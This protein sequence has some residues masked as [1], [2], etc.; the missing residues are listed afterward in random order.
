[1][2]VRVPEQMRDALVREIKRSRL[3]SYLLWFPL[4]LLI[5]V[6]VAAGFVFVRGHLETRV[7]Q[8]ILDGLL[9]EHIL[10]RLLWGTVLVGAS[11][12]LFLLLWQMYREC[13]IEEYL[14][15]EGCKAV[16][17]DETGRCPICQRELSE[18]AGF[19]Y[20]SHSNEEKLLQR[21]GLQAYRNQSMVLEP[22][23]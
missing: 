14:F 11:A 8:R 21:R 22:E 5:F 3:R 15:C 20:T 13:R 19:L 9:P 23:M 12:A 18:S 6:A 2:Y 16:D 10:Q 17:T 4:L 1:M 7:I